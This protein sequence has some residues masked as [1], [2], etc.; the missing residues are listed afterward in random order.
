MGEASISKVQSA[1]EKISSAPGKLSKVSLKLRRSS[2]FIPFVTLFLSL[3]LFIVY[4]LPAGYDQLAAEL[5]LAHTEQDPLTFDKIAKKLES[6]EGGVKDRLNDRLFAAKD[7]NGNDRSFGN[8][9]AEF[10]AV[11]RPMGKIFLDQLIGKD[12]PAII[13]SV[14]STA[15]QLSL[16]S[17]IPGL[18]G[19]IYRRNFF[20]WFL[21]SFVILLGINATGV[22]GSIA[23][24]DEHMPISGGLFLFVVS[25]I[26]ILLLAF[27]V[28]RH[29]QGLE[30][31]RPSVHNGILKVVL[32]FIAIAC[33]MGWGPGYSRGNGEKAAH[34]PA[35]IDQFLDVTATAEAASP[36]STDAESAAIQ[37]AEA[38][39]TAGVTPSWIWN[40]LGDGL[41]RW[42]YKAEFL[43][44]GLPLVY[45]L[46]RNSSPWPARK[47]KYIVICLDGTSNTP[48]QIE[49]GFAAQTNVYK[50][51][52]MLRSTE[53]SY[54]PTGEFDASLCKRYGERQLGLYYAGVGNKYDNNPLLE[55][56]GLATGM[57]ADDIIERAYLDLIRVYRPGDRVV[58]T[59][60]SRGAA[61]ARLLSRMIDARGAP[62]SV[63]TI[64]LF[65]Q[66]RTL[67][68]S[69]TKNPVPI[70]V[71]G[72]WDTVGAFGVAKTIFGINFQQ[73]N[74]GKDLSVPDNVQQAY[75]MVALDERRDS[76]EPTLMDP[77]PIRPERIVEIWFPGDH[78]NIGGGWATDRL[79]D[80]TLDFLLRHISSGY[81]TTEQA[82]HGTEDWGVYLAARKADK[83]DVTC[84][85]DCSNNDVATVD[86]DC[87]GQVRA[88]FSR[89]YVYRPRTLPLHAVI[90]ETVFERLSVMRPA[91]APEALFKL[92]E[93]LDAH[94]DGIV[95]GIGKFAETESLTEDERTKVLDANKSLRLLRWP[96][97]WVD[98]KKKVRRRFDERDAL[99]SGS[100]RASLPTT[101]AERVAAVEAA[102]NLATVLDNKA[103]A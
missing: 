31:L 34:A 78:A 20:G 100:A 5:G 71:L 62:R 65:G 29:A 94:R 101:E 7:A 80:V 50:L 48:D 28:R 86:P 8:Y 38:G 88:W 103:W 83:L 25:Q 52:N 22:F 77:D 35:I 75:H 74:A 70:S 24:G 76:F 92:N 33:V 44:L 54:A 45:T 99:T 81:A 102:L 27:R 68:M 1:S 41:L 26:A 55:V 91:Y 17:I 46:F 14:I 6:N 85:D 95:A 64:Y 79:S 12:F 96:D 9:V 72:C 60:F 51:F 11:G 23:T 3:V 58:I 66:H 39:S 2:R 56:F 90:S 13:R 21:A 67:W 84:R 40:F 69:S 59:G 42:F 32:G 53:G 87:T 98:V 43:F 82:A 57:G 10:Y 30:F 89:L 16:Y 18:A 47:G 63:W 97:Y 37:T 15:W 36:D 49:R 19:L 4:S 93:A 61:I 73:F